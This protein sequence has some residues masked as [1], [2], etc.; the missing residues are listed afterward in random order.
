MKIHG[1]SYG[2]HYLHL[3]PTFL[4]LDD[5]GLSTGDPR[6]IGAWWLGYLMVG[7]LLLLVSWPMFLFPGQFSG[8]PVQTIDL[9]KKMKESGGKMLTI[10][11]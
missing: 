3:N 8:A 11:T 5:S 10:S 2:H 7:L 1:V 9:K 4:L 6:F